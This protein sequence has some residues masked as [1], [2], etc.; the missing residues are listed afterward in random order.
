MRK[1]AMREYAFSMNNTRVSKFSSASLKC[2]IIGFL[3][4]ILFLYLLYAPGLRG[5]QGMLHMGMLVIPPVC[6]LL[7]IV[8]GI[9]SRKANKAK[10]AVSI[11]AFL[12]ILQLLVIFLILSFPSQGPPRRAS[13]RRHMCMQHVRSLTNMCH[14][15]TI[16]HGAFPSS[17][18]ALTSAGYYTRGFGCPTD[19]FVSSR[20]DYAKYGF[21]TAATMDCPPDTPLVGDFDS[22][23]HSNR[24]GHI[25]Y[26]DGNVRWYEGEYEAGSGPLKD[27]LPEDW[28]RQ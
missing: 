18:E 11:G 28:V 22:S 12:L 13:G 14:M 27:V 15:Y 20:T 6:Y 7:G 23:N 24:G 16:D 4:F 3:L 21:N 26:V 25:G 10:W 9:I 2:V 8:F 19:S 5:W 17:F 1:Y